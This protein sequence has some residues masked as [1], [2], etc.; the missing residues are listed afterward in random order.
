MSIFSKG[1]ECSHIFPAL[2]TNC[3]SIKNLIKIQLSKEW[4][5]SRKGM[6]N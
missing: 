6:S 4:P 1:P 2:R 3:S 5:L